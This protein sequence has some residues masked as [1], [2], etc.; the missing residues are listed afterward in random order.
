MLSLSWLAHVVECVC[1]RVKEKR[2][3]WAA[4]G[5]VTEGEEEGR[6]RGREDSTE[7]GR[8]GEK[9]C[10]GREGE[11]ERKEKKIRKRKREGVGGTRVSV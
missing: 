8:K 5:W 2:E 9:S 4:A 1:D 11:K 10:V 6:R 3:R 7:W